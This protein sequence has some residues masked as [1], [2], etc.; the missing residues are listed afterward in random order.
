[1]AGR[2]PGIDE[3]QATLIDL[4]GTA[5]LIASLSECLRHFAALTA[6]AKADARILLTRPI[7]RRDRPTRT[8][9]LDPIDMEEMLSALPK[10][11]SH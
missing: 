6:K 4:D 5:P 10:G 3:Q 7:P 8:W 9:I 1:M 2:E 11:S